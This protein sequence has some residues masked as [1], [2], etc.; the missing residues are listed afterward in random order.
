[1]PQAERVAEGEFVVA[2]RASS[3]SSSTVGE[4]TDRWLLP[5]ALVGPGETYL[6]IQE[7][8]TDTDG[9]TT[10]VFGLCAALGFRFAPRIRDVL[11]QRLFTIGSPEDD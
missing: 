6:H 10:Y 7:H 3:T 9:Y 1:V 8:F 2:C 11:D 4:M 5:A